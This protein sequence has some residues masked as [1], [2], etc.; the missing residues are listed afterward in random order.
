MEFFS[1]ESIFISLFILG[2]ILLGL[3]I[4]KLDE[5]APKTDRSEIFSQKKIIANYKFVLKDKVFLIYVLCVS[6]PAAVNAPG[7][8]LFYVLKLHICTFKQKGYNELHSS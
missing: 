6:F 2:F 5:S 7:F 3:I 8:F 1:W 4:F